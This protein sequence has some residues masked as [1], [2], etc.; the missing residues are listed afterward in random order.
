MSGLDTMIK[1]ILDEAGVEAQAALDRARED[2]ARFLAEA[3]AATDDDCERIVD[4]GRQQ[5]EDIRRRAEATAGMERRRAL[6]TRK[7]F[8][9]DKA[10]QA[11]RV[12]ILN[13]P[14]AEYF[15]FL[16]RL[17]SENAEPGEGVMFLSK[18]DLARLPSG[19]HEALNRALPDGAALDIASE[20]RLIEGGFVLQYGDIDRNCSLAA[21]FDENRERIL[22]AA[23]EAIFQ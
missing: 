19:F 12:A 11:A 3:E 5:A 10:V 23:H 7:Q 13:L 18:K 16:I 20:A 14:E 8:L 21:I 4:E 2:A 6:L 1:I 15:G 22:D 17:A 9:L